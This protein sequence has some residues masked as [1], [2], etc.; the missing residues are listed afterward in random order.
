MKAKRPVEMKPA[1]RRA[2][3]SSYE[4]MMK[5]DITYGAP[6]LKT[7]YRRLILHQ[8]RAFG[9]YLEDPSTSYRPFAW[10]S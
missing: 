2:F 1:I 9:K 8:V 7:A 4:E 6:P 5:R 10:E 3:I